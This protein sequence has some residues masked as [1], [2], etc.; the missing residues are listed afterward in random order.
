MSFQAQP[1]QV[2]VEPKG[3][4]RGVIGIL[5]QG[6]TYLFIRRAAGV[7]KGGAWCFPGGHVEPGETPRLAVVRELKEEL[8]ILVEPVRRLGSVQVTD[9]RHILAVWHVRHVEGRVK[10]DAREIA[11]VQW[12]TAEQIRLMRPTL[13]SNDRV[14]EMLAR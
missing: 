11:E 13:A 6:D 4:R 8:D 14:L 5:N 3:V 9:S 12:L 2:E 1:N 7:A 10:P